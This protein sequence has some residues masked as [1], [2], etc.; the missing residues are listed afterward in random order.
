M[1]A[2]RPTIKVSEG[3]RRVVRT[4]VNNFI[5]VVVVIVAICGGKKKREGGYVIQTA[6]PPSLCQM[7]NE[8]RQEIRVE[9]GVVKHNLQ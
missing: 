8:P 1:V 9:V 7:D 6:V 3:E 2:E 4:K 5:D